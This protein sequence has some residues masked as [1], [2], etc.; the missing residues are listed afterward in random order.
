[1]TKHNLNGQVFGRWTV[2]SQAATRHTPGGSARRYWNCMC[3]CGTARE[4]LQ[5]H[6]LA[7]KSTSCGCY[8]SEVATLNGI[9]HGG[10]DT[11]LYEVWTQMLQRCEN[12]RNKAFAR[13]GSR[14]IKVCSD[15][16]DFAKFD[17]WA[18]ASGY[19]PG[20]TIDRKNNDGGYTPANCR[21]VPN[22]VNCRNTPRTITVQWDGADVPLNTLAEQ[23]GLNP[24]TVYSR[25]KLKGWTL[26]Q[27]LG[28][29]PHP[30]AR[31]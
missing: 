26:R 10:R 7:G 31:R 19:A 4:V 30:G 16:R 9:R 25:F 15:W 27:A 8:Q 17:A 23:R 21:W 3:S 29:E 22:V 14:G 5:Q 28:L 18:A 1:M 6:L 12:P 13:Y 2:M 20:L 24:N 11:L